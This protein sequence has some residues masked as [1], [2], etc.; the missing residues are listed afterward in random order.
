MALKIISLTDLLN[1]DQ[2]EEDIRGLLSSFETIKIKH[3][4]GA[5]DV[6]HFIHTK[7]IQFE[8]MDLSRT[9]LVMSTYQAKPYLA[10]YFSISNRPLVIPK[11]QFQKLSKTLQ[12]RLMGFGHKTQQAT[13]EIK[14]YLLGQLGKNYSSLA[15]KAGNISGAD[16]LTLSYRK[17]LDAHRIVGGR[18][19][20]LECEDH[21]KIKSFYTQNGFKELEHYETDNNLCMM[22]KQI[23]HLMA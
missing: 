22:V 7:A 6:E 2:R 10:G 9:Y 11:K 14:G 19:L 8:K 17:I 4:P 20:Y 12:K 5:E 21:D 16:L 15:Q 13:Y 23:S 1:S 18:I 3:N